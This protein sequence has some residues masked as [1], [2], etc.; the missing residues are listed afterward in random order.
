MSP[1]TESWLI[2]ALVGAGG[3]IIGLFVLVAMCVC[4]RRWRARHGAPGSGRYSKVGADAAGGGRGVARQLELED[5]AGDDEDMV[6]ALFDFDGGVD[7]DD[8]EFDDG[9]L[10]QLQMLEDYREALTTPSGAQPPPVP[11]LTPPTGP[12]PAGVGLG[13]GASAGALDGAGGLGPAA[14]D[15]AASGGTM[16]LSLRLASTPAGAAASGGSAGTMGRKRRSGGRGR[17]SSAVR[18]PG[19]ESSGGLPGAGGASS[20]AGSPSV[21]QTAESEHG[22]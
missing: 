3:G 13:L 22:T 12:R 10:D 2:T 20:P 9:E 11:P 6:D 18:T 17:G 5:R 8:L 15:G 7:D 19:S 1:E 14:A 21:A 16:S 4:Y